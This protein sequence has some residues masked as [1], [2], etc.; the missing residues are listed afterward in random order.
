[1]RKLIRFLVIASVILL[2][3]AG[4]PA[5][6]KA[7]TSTQPPVEQVSSAPEALTPTEPETSTPTPPPVGVQ[8]VLAELFTGDW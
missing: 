2:S 7:V 8:V 4:L 5:C 1:M 3:V 6:G